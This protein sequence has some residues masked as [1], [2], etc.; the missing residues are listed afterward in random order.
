[1]AGILERDQPRIRN[2]RRQTLAMLEGENWIVPAVDHQ[3]RH[4]Y[5]SELAAPSISTG[6]HG[7]VQS[8]PWITRTVEFALGK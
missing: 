2:R 6:Q 4:G 3:H 8:G 1:M 7:V 5:P